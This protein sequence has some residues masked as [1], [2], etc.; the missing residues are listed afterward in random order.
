MHKSRSVQRC[1]NPNPRHSQ[2]TLHA[3]KHTALL[4]AQCICSVCV[5]T[6]KTLNNAKIG[7][8]ATTQHQYINAAYARREFGQMRGSTLRPFQ[9]VLEGGEVGG[10]KVRFGRPWNYSHPSR[11]A[12]FSL[13]S[14]RSMSTGPTDAIPSVQQKSA[15]NTRQFRYSYINPTQGNSQA[16]LCIYHP[17]Y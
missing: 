2:C 5:T 1:M 9:R 10:I 15:A 12:N 16:A 3:N 11:V 8:F 13:S 4:I 7:V 6:D 17:P 14:A